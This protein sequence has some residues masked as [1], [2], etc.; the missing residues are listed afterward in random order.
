MLVMDTTTYLINIALIALVIR[1]VRERRLD[2][3][4]LV[5]PIVL[6]G[7]A[8]R[9]YL[10]DVPTAGND[11]AFDVIL[12]GAGVALG[13]ICGVFTHMRLDDEGF[14]L[15][16]AGVIAAGAWIVG[17]GTRMGVEIAS[18]HGLGPAITRFSVDHHLT[19]AG[20]WTT[21][22][23]LMALCEVTVRLTIIQL[24]RVQMERTARSHTKL[25]AA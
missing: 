13:T 22:F 2:L 8:A 3:Q 12:A 14:V 15:A 9:H 6:V 4:S 17:I 25:V 16:R 10:T 5:L 18:D 24:R 21:A 23:V 20:A 7:F 19:S 11:V 1:Q